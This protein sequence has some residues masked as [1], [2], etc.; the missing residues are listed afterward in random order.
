MREISWFR[1]RTRHNLLRPALEGLAS[2]GSRRLARTLL[3]SRA[4]PEF[5]KLLSITLSQKAEILA[6]ARL[7][8]NVDVEQKKLLLGADMGH[9]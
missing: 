5:V 9:R 2:H 1:F 8:A 7:L 6:V 4:H 3:Q